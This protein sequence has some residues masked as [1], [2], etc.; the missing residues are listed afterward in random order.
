M[1]TKIQKWG[2]S[3]AVRL[4]KAIATEKALTEG[5][6]VLV[7]IKHDQI[8]IEPDTDESLDA[9]TARIT[10]ENLH[11][12]SDWGTKVGNEVW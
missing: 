6:G 5:T 9:L 4:P 2:N 1:K 12:E 11:S 3:L 8:V 10:P 7:S